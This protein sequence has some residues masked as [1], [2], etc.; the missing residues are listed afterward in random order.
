MTQ[1]GKYQDV[2]TLECDD[3]RVL[4]SRVPGDDGKWTEFMA[5][6]YRRRK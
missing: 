2:I 6:H 5:A 3:H 1:A 4:T